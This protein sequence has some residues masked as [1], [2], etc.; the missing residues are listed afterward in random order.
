MEQISIRLTTTERE[1]AV[2]S[3]TD[4]LERLQSEF[5]LLG[6]RLYRHGSVVTDLRVILESDRHTSLPSEPALRLTAGLGAMGIVHHTAWYLA[7]SW[8]R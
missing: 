3:L 6:V 4:H 8:R 2:A 5:D 7:E 1:E